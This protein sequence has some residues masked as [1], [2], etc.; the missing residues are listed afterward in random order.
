MSSFSNEARQ[1]LAYGILKRFDRLEDANINFNFNPDHIYI[2]ALHQSLDQLS[3]SEFIENNVELARVAQVFEE[4][5]STPMIGVN[6]G[7]A[8]LVSAS[9][10]WLAGYTANSLVVAKLLSP[11]RDEFSLTGQVLLSIFARD[12]DAISNLG[13]LGENLGVYIRTG[14]QA[15]IERAITITKI[16]E[17]ESLDERIADEFV[18]ARLLGLIVQRLNRISFWSSIQNSHSAPAENFVEYMRVL[19]RLNRPIIDLWISQRLA[20]SRGLIDGESSLVIS[21]PTSSGKTKMTELAFVND[22]FTDESRKCLYLAPFRALV[23]EVD[24]DISPVFSG[25]GISTVSLYGGGDA[26]EIEVELAEKARL[27]IATPEKIS[28]ILKLSGGKITD[29]QTIVLDE[30]HLV[31]SINRGVSY[32]FQLAH[33]RSQLR[34]NTRVVF[35]SAVL[36]NSNELAG[37]LIGTPERLAQTDWQP[38]SMRIGVVNWLSAASSPRLTYEFEKGQPL[39]EDFFIPRLFT[40]EEWREINPKTGRNR[41]HRFP[42][43]GDNGSISASL[44]FQYSKLGQVII[45]AQRPDWAVSIA[46]KIIERM[47]LERPIESDWISN[48]NQEKLSEIAEYFEKRIGSDSILVKSLKRGFAVHHGKI[49][50]S[51]RTVIEDAFRKQII[52]VLIA[53]NTIAQGVNFPAKTLIVHSLPRSETSV[54]DFWNLAGRAGR[55]S[56]ET[57]GEVVVLQTGRLRNN[58]LQ[59]FIERRIE[60]VNSKIF[61]LVRVIL[62][63]YPSISQETIETFMQDDNWG[64]VIKSI[65]TQLL[66]LMAEEITDVEN[67]NDGG[68]VENII[69]N[70][71]CVFQASNPELGNSA[72]IQEGINSLLQIRRGVVSNLVP[73]PTLKKRFAKTG[74]NI[75]SSIALSQAA[76][77]IKTILENNEELSNDVFS[78]LVDIACQTSELADVN[79]NNVSRLGLVWMRSG[80]YQTVYL[81]SDKDELDDAVHFVEDVLCYRLP[82][83]INGMARLLESENEDETYEMPDWFVWLPKYLRYGVDSKELAWI[84]SLGIDDRDFAEFLLNHYVEDNEIQ[85]TSF[86]QFLSWA[87]EN[88]DDLISDSQEEWADYFTEIL[89]QVLDR[90]SQINQSLNG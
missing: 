3:S 14:S 36:P 73:D 25:L 37:W 46:K 82:W 86:R 40:Q 47:D 4:F 7:F 85:P 34:E 17:D 89:T 2:Q 12:I 84:T 65:D 5:V 19:E 56:R 43:Y 66:E 63:T 71:Y 59:D 26:N 57:L 67:G 55:A 52:K 77:Q 41:L 58:V 16:I 22:L 75:D 21:T 20:I 83:V 38:T 23:S 64:E 15:A 68:G 74:L 70:L 69:Q 87:I 33:I 18:L 9:V 44:A 80:N 45:Y 30:G 50:Q 78:S 28:A 6:Q 10:Y 51:F 53:T 11:R 61:E 88:K 31:D 81:E 62:E 13:E 48:S 27:T 79:R 60:S 35:L 29:Y 76:D 90:Y 54:R 39:M 32:E 1:F 8:V 42:V 72:E 24:H 49:P